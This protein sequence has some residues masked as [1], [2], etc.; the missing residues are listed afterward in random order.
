MQPKYQ[1][2][3]VPGF[4]HFPERCPGISGEKVGVSCYFG[5]LALYKC[6]QII[7]IAWILRIFLKL[8][9]FSAKVFRKENAN[10]NPDQMVAG[11]ILWACWK[12]Q[13]LK[14]WS[15]RLMIFWYFGPP[16][17]Q[18]E[19]IPTV[20]L[21]LK[22]CSQVAVEAC[23]GRSRRREGGLFAGACKF[24]GMLSSRTNA[25]YNSGTK[26]RKENYYLAFS[27][28]RKR[29]KTWVPSTDPAPPKKQLASEI[30]ASSVRA[31]WSFFASDSSPARIF[32]DQISF[33]LHSGARSLVL[34]KMSASRW[35]K[36]EWQSKGSVSS[37]AS[38]HKTL[39]TPRCIWNT[40]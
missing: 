1:H 20:Y 16:W 26:S 6:N 40:P 13:F 34:Y 8:S 29:R 4:S 12:S 37:A 39:R 36:K 7:N 24:Q 25:W 38:V 15:E 27:S 14:H 19:N 33:E 17:S 2:G 10:A 9:T 32:P 31:S 30:D 35:T 21:R 3:F 18:H 28:T 22:I 5:D 11:C 23:G